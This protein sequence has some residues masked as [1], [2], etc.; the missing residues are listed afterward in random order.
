VPS[1]IVVEEGSEAPN[2]ME[3]PPVESETGVKG[4]EAYDEPEK[5]PEVVD[6][7]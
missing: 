5:A 4:E 1:K 2:D 7:Y 6:E 3:K